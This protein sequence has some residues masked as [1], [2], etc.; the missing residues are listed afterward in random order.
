MKTIDYYQKSIY[1]VSKILDKSIYQVSMTPSYYQKSIYQ[2]S[3]TPN[4]QIF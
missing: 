4:S 2:V 1:Q 3:M